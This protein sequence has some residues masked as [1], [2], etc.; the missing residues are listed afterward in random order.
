MTATTIQYNILRL[1]GSPV[2]FDRLKMCLGKTRLESSLPYRW[3][4]GDLA[5]TRNPS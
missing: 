2:P 1:H 3:D 4:C 5:V